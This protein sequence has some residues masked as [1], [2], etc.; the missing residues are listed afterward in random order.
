MRRRHRRIMFQFERDQPA[1]PP[2]DAGEAGHAAAAAG[3]QRGEFGCRI[4]ILRLDGD[5]AHP[6]V[7]GGK[8]ASSRAS[9][10]GLSSGTKRWSSAARSLR[11]EE[12]T[13]ELP[14][15]MRISYA[16]FCLKKKKKH[17]NT[18]AKDK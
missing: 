14:S 8:I 7:T 11:S 5:A 12:H 2:D 1:I 13:S 15:L 6:P 17:E 9:P 18:H 16:V 10:M 4:E 3:L